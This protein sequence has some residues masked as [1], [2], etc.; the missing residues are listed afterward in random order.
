MVT[1]L[2][3]AECTVAITGHTFRTAHDILEKYAERTSKLAENAIAK[4]ENALETD[5]AKRAAKCG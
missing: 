4:F 2:S 1:L 3:E 5:F